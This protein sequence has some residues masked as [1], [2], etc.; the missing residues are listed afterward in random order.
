MDIRAIELDVHWVPSPSGTAETG[1]FWVT[2]C[3]GDGGNP[4]NVHIGC[5]NDRPFQDGLQEVAVWLG[6]HPDQFVLLYLENQLSGNAAAH[7]LAGRL[8]QQYLGGLVE[9]PST[10]CA[11]MDWNTSQAAMLARHHQVAIVGNCSAGAGNAWGAMVHERGPR[12]DEHGDPDGYSHDQCVADSAARRADS[13]FRRYFED[14]TWMAATAGS[15]PVTSSLGG[16]STITTTATKQMVQCGVNIIGFDQLT[17]EDPRLA[18]LV[19]S[20]APDEPR[21]T[22]DGGGNCAYQSVKSRFVAGTCSDRRAVACATPSG[23][24]LVTK[25]RVVWADAATACST[26][27]PGSRFAVPANGYRNRTLGVAKPAGTTE[28]WLNYRVRGG[29]W[30]AG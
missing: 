1:G 13:T 25:A 20:W 3:H 27:F 19:W 21:A 23:A 8:I 15:N 26:E 11:A 14:S 5:T 2:L 28:V 16:T 24:W 17:P 7:D 4:L 6:Q 30:T 12:W 29:T 22:A 18:A 9:R 10:P